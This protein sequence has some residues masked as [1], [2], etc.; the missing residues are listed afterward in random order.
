MLPAAM[1][2]VLFHFH[3]LGQRDEKA[4]AAFTATNW[5]AKHKQVPHIAQAKVRWAQ[6]GRTAFS[7]EHMR[8]HKK[9][10]SLRCVPIPEESILLQD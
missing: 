7:A 2:V 8:M 1:F 4:R 3:G 9:P 10:V 6:M 5:P